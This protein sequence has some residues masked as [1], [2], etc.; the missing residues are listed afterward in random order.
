[1][2]IMS[3][4]L[5]GQPR[6]F[7]RRV[8]FSGSTALYEGQAVCFDRDY[9]TAAAVD[10]RRDT[11]VELPNASN[12]MWFAGVVSRDY[13]AVTGGQTIEIYE[14]GSICRIRA[15]VNATVGQTVLTFQAP[16]SGFSGFWN[17][18]YMRGTGAALAL[19]TLQT[20]SVISLSA[21][22]AYATT[23]KVLTDTG[24]NFV[25][26]GV[27][28]GDTLVVVGG[29][30]TR[31]IYT[32]ASVTDATK[33]VLTKDIGSTGVTAIYYIE[34]STPLIPALLLTGAQVG[35]ID[36]AS[37]ST[38]TTLSAATTTSL[39]VANSATV[40]FPTPISDQT[41]VLYVNGAAASK[42]LT[43]TNTTFTGGYTGISYANVAASAYLVGRSLYGTKYDIVG[44]N[45]FTLA[46]STGSG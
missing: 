27:A 28:A 26:A 29:T 44:N 19:Q 39:Y 1:M 22:A 8:W 2:N 17:T 18:A 16:A 12:C 40:T 43:V 3:Q 20:Y 11:V 7:R 25:T 33:I 5:G 41:K 31:G 15:G 32:I 9:G 6:Q 4:Y 30:A 38:D 46:T 45:G 36:F 23:G 13:P 35:G 24:A 10:Y 14:P 37:V 42:T 21:I 34:K